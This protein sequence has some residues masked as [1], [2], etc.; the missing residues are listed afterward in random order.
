MFITLTIIF[1]LTTCLFGY[2]SWLGVKKQEKLEDLQETQNKILA[3]YMVYL[4]KINDIIG[5]SSKKLKEIDNRGIFQSDDE[6]GWFFD[7]IKLIQDTLDK[8]TI[9]NL[10]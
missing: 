9:E 5:F 8:F 4:N 3:G 1:F 7:Q 10:K 2:T 6:I